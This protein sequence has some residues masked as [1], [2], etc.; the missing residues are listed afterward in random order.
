M[1]TLNIDKT[2]GLLALLI[3]VVAGIGVTIPYSVLL[4]LVL[5]GVHGYHA[6]SE[7]H[8]RVI[9]TALA[10]TAFASAL[11]VVPEA[12]GYL[13]AVAVNLGKFAQGAALLIILRNFYLHLMPNKAAE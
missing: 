1:T 5:G 7:S 13:E 11:A 9:V 8:V 12:G 3:A 10:I 6:S 2:I 4:L